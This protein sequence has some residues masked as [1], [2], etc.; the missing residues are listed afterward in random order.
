M[1]QI[2]LIMIGLS[3]LVYAERFDRSIEGVVTDS[4]THLQWQ[5]DYSDNSGT[6]KS[7]AWTDA[8]DYCESLPLDGGG[9]RLP[10][11]NELTSLVDD[12]VYGPSISPVFLNTA[13]IHYWSS[14]THERYEDRAWSVLF[15]NGSQYHS[16]KT[17]NGSVRCVRAG[18]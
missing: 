3:T 4:I 1:K 5:D 9:W 10:N 16:A 11:L 7:A 6:I 14:T 17:T 13:Y 15:N 18:Q 12:R 2:L 8:I